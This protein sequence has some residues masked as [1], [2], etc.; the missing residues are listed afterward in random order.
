MSIGIACWRMGVLQNPERHRRLLWAIVCG[1]GACI[2]TLQFFGWSFD[3]K[4]NLVAAGYAAA[5]F[6]WASY[7]WRSE[8]LAAAGQMALTNY[9][10]QSVILSLLFFGYG[11]GMFG[12]LD[13][14]PGALIGVVLYAAQLAFSRAWL[15]RYRFGPVE[16]LWR[17]LTY[18]CAQPMRL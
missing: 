4:P 18:G 15:R 7:G 11:L 1:A 3:M 2:A 10:T 17:S 9:L 6:L 8:S 14:A 16:W 12:R 5:I 13:A